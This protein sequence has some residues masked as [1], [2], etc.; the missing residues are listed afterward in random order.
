MKFKKDYGHKDQK[1]TKSCIITSFSI[2]IMPLHIEHSWKEK[3]SSILGWNLCNKTLNQRLNGRLLILLHVTLSYI[4]YWK[5]TYGA[6]IMKIT[7]IWSEQRFFS[8][9]AS[10]ERFSVFVWWVDLSL[11]Q[12][13]ECVDNQGN[14]IEK[15]RRTKQI[16]TDLNMLSS[17]VIYILGDFSAEGILG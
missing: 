12:M 8:Q 5:T 9:R 6:F 13:S 1:K 16:N 14:S 7:N 11:Q 15:W 17:I 3:L 2:M 10:Q 4:S